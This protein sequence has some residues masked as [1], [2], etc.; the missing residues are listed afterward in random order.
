MNIPIISVLM[1]VY[2]AGAFLK[3]GIDS[4]LQQTYSDFELIIINDGSNDNSEQIILSFKD[5]RIKY[6]KNE[7]NSGLIFTLNKGLKYCSGKFIARMDAD[8][9]SLPDR[10]EKQINYIEKNP[11]LSG[12]GCHVSFIN[13]KAAVIGTWKAD[14]LTATYLQIKKHIVKENCIAHPSVMVRA[15]ILKEYQYNN[16]QQH[17]EDYDLWL[18]LFA[19]GLKMEKV[20]EKLLLYRIHQT[21]VT[22]SILRK[23]NPFFDQFRCKIKFL[24]ARCSHFSFGIF[25]GKV[26][27]TALTDYIMGIGKSIKQLFKN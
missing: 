23:S 8:D 4:I 24:F 12:V 15:S 10:F 2:N 14:E 7:K 21:S 1:P 16:N 11:S 22:S 17:I 18:R 19:D 20:P 6:Y 5:P 9:I 13:E 3:V 26:L 27:M 25:E